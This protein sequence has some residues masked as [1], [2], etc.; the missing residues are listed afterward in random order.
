MVAQ[1]TDLWKVVT[2]AG[3]DECWPCFSGSGDGRGHKHITYSGKKIYAHRI[4]YE[5]T[6]GAI[7]EGALI[8]HTCANPACCNPKHLVEGTHSENIKQAYQDN[9]ALLRSRQGSNNGRSKLSY[10]QVADIRAS[11]LSHAA[12]GRLYGVSEVTIGRVRKGLRYA[13]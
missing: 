4:A 11:T 5:L 2:K 13:S 1:K 6:K 3:D 7:T 12:C 8:L 9:T 10:N